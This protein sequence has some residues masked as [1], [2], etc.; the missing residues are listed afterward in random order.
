[1][2]AAY[3]DTDPTNPDFPSYTEPIDDPLLVLG[4]IVGPN[5][6]VAEPEQYIRF[7][8]GVTKGR[9]ESQATD[10]TRL[11]T[12]TG[13]VVN[14][15]LDT[16]GPEGVPDGVIDIYDVPVVTMTSMPKPQKAE[17]IT[18]TFLKTKLMWKPS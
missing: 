2:V 4:L 14:A 18:T 12:Y 9:G 7:D 11:F 16:S 17:T 10:I 5:V 1:M 3:N 15:R 6:Y 8:P 13:W